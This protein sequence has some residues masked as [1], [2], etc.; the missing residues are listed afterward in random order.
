MTR[1]IYTQ[2]QKQILMKRK[3][4]MYLNQST[5]HTLQLYKVYKKFRKN[6]C[7]DC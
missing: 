2:K 1:F 7:L 4:M 3:L 6:F 5:L